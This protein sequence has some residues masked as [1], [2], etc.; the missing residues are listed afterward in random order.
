[1]D[2]L[3]RASLSSQ[4]LTLG[5]DREPARE[6]GLGALQNKPSTPGS[7]ARPWEDSR[8]PRKKGWLV[9][10]A[11]SSGGDGDRSQ[12]IATEAESRGEEELE[13]TDEAQIGSWGGPCC[14]CCFFFP[15]RGSVICTNCPSVPAW[16]RPYE[17]N[18]EPSLLFM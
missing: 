10:R 11:A 3:A 1:M 7:S 2:A 13:Q 12:S 14:C 17:G 4:A 9:L 15:S 18:L 8:L 16:E 5:L 6:P